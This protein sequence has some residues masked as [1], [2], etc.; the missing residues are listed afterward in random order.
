M[1]VFNQK[2]QN[3]RNFLKAA[4][5]GLVALTALAWEKLVKTENRLSAGRFVSVP[6]NPNKS[7]SFH[8]EF[9]IVNGAGQTVVFSSHCTHLGCTIN[10]SKNGELLCPCH[11]STFD[12]TGNP[13]KG[14]ATRQLDKKTFVINEATGQIE[15]EL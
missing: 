6:F 14:P 8:K 1:P 5:I 2:S 15:I 9:I 13:L 3:R 12:L 4:G 11:G 10:N 7:I